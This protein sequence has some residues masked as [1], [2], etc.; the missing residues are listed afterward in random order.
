[1]NPQQITVVDSG[2]SSTTGIGGQ[3]VV[4]GTPTPGSFVEVMCAGAETAVIQVA[5]GFVATLVVEK[6]LDG[7]TTWY[8]DD[9]LPIGET[10]TVASITV[11]GAASIDVSGFTNLRVRCT[12][13]T[14]GPV[15]VGIV[16]GQVVNPQ[17]ANPP[18]APSSLTA[19]GEIGSIFLSWSSATGAVTYNV[20]RS[21]SSGGEGGLPL[22]SGIVGTTLS[23]TSTVPGT[24]YYYKVSAVNTAGESA[25]SN[26]ASASSSSVLLGGLNYPIGFFTVVPLI[27]QDTNYP[28]GFGVG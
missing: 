8:L 24:T 13:F 6:S 28:L 23:D 20:Y 2:S 21:L 3:T 27:S 25:M 14:S 7:G 22:A 17:Q 26:E 10:S 4:T 16:P 19:V 15:V 5:P 1:M 11:L 9:P 12:A 18:V